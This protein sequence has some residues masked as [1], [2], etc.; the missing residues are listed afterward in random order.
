MLK[1]TLEVL[2]NPPAV[3]HV[4]RRQVQPIS[5]ANQAADGALGKGVDA[6]LQKVID[7]E[8]GRQLRQVDSRGESHQPVAERT[9][10]ALSVSFVIV[11]E[12]LRFGLKRALVVLEDVD[13][14]G[15]GFDGRLKNKKWG[16]RLTGLVVSE[17]GMKIGC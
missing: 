17:T 11:A 9:D 13:E 8:V 4:C 3:H 5:A 10:T 6:V 15:S 2:E 16:R 1:G 7:A 12:Q 14:A